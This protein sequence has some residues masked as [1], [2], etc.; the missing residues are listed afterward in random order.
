MCVLVLCTL[1][2]HFEKEK[3]QHILTNPLI[4][5]SIVEKVYTNTIYIVCI[6]MYV[7][8][9][10]CRKGTLVYKD[11]CGQWVWFVAL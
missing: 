3:G 11:G 2:I 4:V 6:Y 5:N 1:G 7:C 9:A 10:V 8:V